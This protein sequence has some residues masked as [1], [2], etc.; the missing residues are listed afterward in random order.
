MEKL[1]VEV[2]AESLC[3]KSASCPAGHVLMDPAHPMDGLPSIRV[4]ASGGGDVCELHLHP[5]YGNFELHSPIELK[6]GEI[7]EL[8]CPECHVPLTSQE[9]RCVFCDAPMFVLNLPKGGLV[10]GCTRKGCHNHKLKVVDLNAQLAD[11][12][13]LDMRPRF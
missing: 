13:D 2:P 1:I 10:C 11:L 8:S 9:E 12:F 7:Y 3:I 4:L 6:E 5:R